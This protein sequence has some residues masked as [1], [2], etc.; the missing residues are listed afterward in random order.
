MND[1]DSSQDWLERDEDWL[2]YS[3]LPSNAAQTA[4]KEDE[5]R[6]VK[7]LKRDEPCNDNNDKTIDRPG[8]TCVICLLP[9]TR[10]TY[11]I[12]CLHSFC[13]DCIAR[14]LK[15][16]PVCP[17]C[18]QPPRSIAMLAEDDNNEDNTSN[19]DELTTG[20]LIHRTL[21]EL[22]P[23]PCLPGKWHNR[24]SVYRRS[25][26]ADNPPR[27]VIVSRIKTHH[28]RRLRPFVERE[29]SA[30]LGDDN[31]DIVMTYTIEVLLDT[32]PS[33]VTAS[34]SDSDDV[35]RERLTQRLAIYLGNDAAVFLREIITFLESGRDMKTF[36]HTVSYTATSP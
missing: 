36:D 14:W 30:L 9:W 4:E 7:R 18:K 2:T 3:V 12:D 11:L 31:D 24:R 35:W 8:Q 10:R 6:K 16:Q 29:L 33:F 15:H 32:T 34:N 21:D 26:R 1:D 19:S 23:P 17:L 25:L 5:N 20:Q 22:E 27:N 28:L 13:F